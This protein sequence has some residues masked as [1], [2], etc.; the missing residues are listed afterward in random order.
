MLLSRPPFRSP[1]RRALRTVHSNYPIRID[2]H[3]ILQET[4]VDKTLGT[5]FDSN[6]QI[7]TEGRNRIAID[8]VRLSL[9]V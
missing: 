7:C 6:L 8:D 1:C 2:P 3:A 9:N 5:L 4:L